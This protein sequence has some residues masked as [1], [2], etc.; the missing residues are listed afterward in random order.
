METRPGSSG[1]KTKVERERERRERQSDGPLRIYGKTVTNLF[2]AIRTQLGGEIQ[3]KRNQTL[4]FCIF[5]LNCVL[6]ER[7]IGSEK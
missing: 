1:S 2:S 6:I 5:F 4:I 7:N 3:R